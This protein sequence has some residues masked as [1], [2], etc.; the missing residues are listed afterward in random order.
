MKRTIERIAKFENLS[1]AYISSYRHGTP[2][3]IR[4]IPTDRCNL[5]CSYCWQRDNQSAD[6]SIN[7]FAAYL[8]KAKELRV[9]YGLS[10]VYM[11]INI[12]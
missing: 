10:N 5:N 9:P 3:F 7:S 12:L 11:L 4:M 6:M 8:D 2:A 1:K